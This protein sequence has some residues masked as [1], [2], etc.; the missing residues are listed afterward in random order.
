MAEIIKPS[1]LDSRVKET[2]LS[3]PSHHPTLPLERTYCV[4]C[5]RP[6]GWVSTETYDYIRVNNIIVLCDTCN[7]ALGPGGLPECPIEEIK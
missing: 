3:I 4:S 7:E 2:N 1:D 5:G 6:K